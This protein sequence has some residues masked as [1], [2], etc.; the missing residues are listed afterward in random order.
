MNPKPY[1]ESCDQN[2]AP[3]FEVINPLL[4]DK[5]HVLEIGSGTGQHAVYFAKKMPHLI[6]QCSDQHIY[7]PGIK[8]WLQA[9]NLNNTP[10]PIRLDV[11]QD[12]WPALHDIDVIFSAN[13][14]HMMSWE[15]VVDFIHQA[16]K[17]LIP[18]GLLLLYGPFNYEQQ[19]TSES[20]AQF[21]RWLKQRDPKSGIRDFEAMNQLAHDAQLS[22]VQ[23]YAMP[24][25]NRILCWLKK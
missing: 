15:N 19:Y 4:Q 11:S 25:N 14:V 23:D 1:S 17:C 21:D 22:F 3:I 16:G 12:Q 20:N 18:N 9:G 8:Q 5:Q 2:K 13:A 10:D 7:L 24:A 6:W